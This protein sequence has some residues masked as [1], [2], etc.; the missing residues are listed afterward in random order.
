MSKFTLVTTETINYKVD[1]KSCILCPRKA[2]EKL[3]APIKKTGKIY[4]HYV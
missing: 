1:W 2:K 4:L 3:V